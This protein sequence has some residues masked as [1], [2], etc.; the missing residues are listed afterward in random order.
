MVQKLPI[1]SY[2]FV[3]KFDRYRYGQDKNYGCFIIM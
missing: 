2:K 1:G 3:S